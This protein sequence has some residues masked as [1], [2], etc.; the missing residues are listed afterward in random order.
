MVVAKHDRAHQELSRQ[1]ADREVEKE[2][3]ALV[4]G[5]VQAGRADRRADRPRSERAAEDVDAGAP[6][7]GAPS[8][9]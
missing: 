9:G 1:F 8:R 7:R 2:Y 3:I 6:A 4:W 5:V